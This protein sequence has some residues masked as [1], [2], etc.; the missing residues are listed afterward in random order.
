MPKTSLELTPDRA[1]AFAKLALKGIGREYPNKPGH[2]LSGPAD[3]KTPRAL[4]PAFYGCYDW[5]SAVHG[6]WMLARLLRLYPD[7]PEAKTIRAAL[8]E[9]LTTENLQAEA[10]YFRKPDNKSFERTYGWAWLLKLAQELHDWDDPDAKVWSKNI[11][12][13]VE[14][15]V[16]RYL[17]FFPKQT[18]PIRTGVHPDTAFGLAFA[19]DYAAAV[20]DEKL[21]KLVAERA[22]SYFG[23]DADAPAKWE[24]GGA[25]FFSPCLMEADLMRRVLPAAEFEQWFAKFLPGAAKG[26]PKNLFD[27]AIVSDRSDLQ[28]V[29]LDGLNLSRAWCMEGIAGRLPASNPARARLLDSS[30]RHAAAALEHVASGHYGGEHWL[31]SFAVYL[32]TEK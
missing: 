16:T 1:S 23:K 15:V 14:I 13:L 28:I 19:Y 18:Y 3:L 8:C 27:P 2:A 24:P 32:L 26:E 17:E 21:K 5:H 6:H 31:A 7:L 9:H 20:G 11:Q 12:P 30:Q 10:D 22:K 4:H 29:H 25:D